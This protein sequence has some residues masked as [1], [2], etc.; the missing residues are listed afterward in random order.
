MIIYTLLLP[1]IRNK[2]LQLDFA[3]V[4]DIS[5]RILFKKF[6]NGHI[7]ISLP[8]VSLKTF[9]INKRESVSRQPPAEP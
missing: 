7:V 5:Q 9:E 4:L 8:G 1:A 6:H 3:G 2:F